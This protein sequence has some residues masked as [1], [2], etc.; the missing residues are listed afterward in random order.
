MPVDEF[1]AVCFTDSLVVEVVAYTSRVIEVEDDVLEYLDVDDVTIGLVVNVPTP[2]VE[3]SSTGRVVEVEE[4]EKE[5]DRNG[6]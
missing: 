3:E 1:S 6:G 4:E 2:F 5:V